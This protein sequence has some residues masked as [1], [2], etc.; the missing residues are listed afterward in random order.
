MGNINTYK[1]AAVGAQPIH[2]FDFY[3][4]DGTVLSLASHSLTYLGTPYMGRVLQQ[5]V[6]PIQALSPHGIDIPG[7]VRLTLADADKSLYGL[8]QTKD[9]R[10]AR[11]VVTFAYYDFVAAIWSA[12]AMVPFVGRCDEPEVGDDSLTVTATFILNLEAKYLPAF[13]IQPRCPKLFPASLAAKGLADTKGSPYYACGVTDPTKL[14]CTFDKAGCAANANS[15]RFGGFPWEVPPAS[16]S[17]E[18]TSGN[19]LTDLRS[20]PNAAKYGDYAPIGYG[21]AWVDCLVMGSWPEANSTR[22]EAIVCEGR[23]ARILKVTVEDEELPPANDL[24]GNTFIVKDPL[25]RYNVIS[26]G[27]RDGALNMDHPW[28]GNGD[29]G[30]SVCRIEWVVYR[31]LTGNMPRVRALIEFPKVRGYAKIATIVG[32]VVTLANGAPN[33]DIAGNPPYTIRIFGNSNGALNATFGLTSWSYGPPGTVTLTGSAASGAGGYIEYGAA[34]NKYAWAMLDVLQRAGMS[35]DDAALDWWID[36]NLKHTRMVNFTARDGSTQTHEKYTCSVVVRQRRPVADLLTGLQRG[37]ASH[38]GRDLSTG[39]IALF[40]RG[41]LAEQQPAPVDG[42][43]YSTAIAGGFVAYHFDESSMV[44]DGAKM[45]RP[46]RAAGAISNVV[47]VPFSNEEN[48]YSG[49]SVQVKDSD[50]INLMGQEIGGNFQVEGCN[51]L[52]R[53]NRVGAIYLAEQLGGQTWRWISTAKGVRLTVEQIVA[54]SS[55][56][57]DFALQL[58]RIRQISPEANYERCTYDLTLHDDAWY[59][60][61]FE[62]VTGNPATAARRNRLARPSWAWRPYEVQPASGDPLYG[63]TDWT[64]GLQLSYDALRDGGP[65]AVATITGLQPVNEPANLQPPVLARQGTTAS[66]GGSLKGSGTVYF[67]AVAMRDANGRP[68]PLSAPCVTPVAQAGVVN[69][70]TA[71]VEYWDPAGSGYFVFVGLSPGTLS[72][73]ND[74]GFAGT[75]ASVTVTDLPEA[76]WG[77]PDT[78]FDRLLVRPKYVWHEGVFGAAI[79]APPGA[80]TITIAGAGWTVNQWAG[81]DCTVSAK[82]DLS[83][84]AVLNFRVASNTA[85]VLAIDGASPDPNALGVAA[86]DVLV[87]LSKPTVGGVGSKTL[88]D[89]NWANTLSN[90]GLGL[91]AHQEQGRIL[92]II[93]GKGRG[94]KYKIDDNTSTA[95]TIAGDWVVTPDSTSRYVIEDAAALPE[96]GDS[97]SVSNSDQAAGI[98]IRIP[99]ANYA[100]STILLEAVTVDGGGNESA[101]QNN[102]VRMVY[103][104]GAQGTREIVA[105]DAMQTTDGTV[106]FDTTAIT[107]GSTTLAAAMTDTTSQGVTLTS[108]AALIDGQCFQIG[109]E[110]LRV[111]SGGGTTTP[112]CERGAKGST[113]AT[114]SN[115]AAVTYGGVLTYTC[116]PAAS[117]PNLDLILRKVSTDLSGVKILAAGGDT[118]PGGGTAIYLWDESAGEGTARIKF[119]GL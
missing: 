62:S 86:G 10:G 109:M 36:A 44:R 59:A 9:F 80:R 61:R 4:A 101:P 78:E 60:D 57:H 102:P 32:G 8:D 117:V 13:P 100:G 75:P 31:K 76:T 1:E 38:I 22:G 115:G 5:A 54:V 116:L 89:A 83:A 7:Q 51:S 84:L 15:M 18:Y 79:S 6:D 43:N 91:T 25:F 49:D 14:S 97:D 16:R 11:L 50:D 74:T 52:D 20:D 35:M 77:P 111:L 105:D 106:L 88:T 26:T 53:A 67:V 28:D 71:A 82:G 46:G 47:T 94:Y 66:S 103:V 55:V 39:K 118:W 87:M 69:T 41:D 93:A 27:D 45:S 3:W 85:T 104:P 12:D 98:Q 73:T 37:C 90:G 119:P 2:L 114:H 21:T 40:A 68:G 30:G 24:D 58:M 17:R 63:R 56:K 23:P 65:Q 99:L 108:G 92:R 72:A 107:G 19:W 64:F 113:A 110:I 81:Y 48:D 34:S 112:T 70:I 95:V 42:S 33:A 29:P 96:G